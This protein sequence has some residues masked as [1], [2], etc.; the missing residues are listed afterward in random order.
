MTQVLQEHDSKY[1]I[2]NCTVEPYTLMAYHSINEEQNTDAYIKHLGLTRHLGLC[3][4]LSS[5]FGAH[6]FHYSR[7]NC[8]SSSRPNKTSVSVS[9]G[10]H[11]WGLR[12]QQYRFFKLYLGKSQNCSLQGLAQLSIRLQHI[13]SCKCAPT[14]WKIH[15]PSGNHHA[16]HFYTCSISRS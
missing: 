6:S 4:I 16:S 14:G 13:Y 3:P 1:N 11:D 2:S 8:I 5:D 9:V 15:Y 10:L 7:G 12:Y